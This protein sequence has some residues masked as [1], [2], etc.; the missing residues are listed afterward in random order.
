MRK[1][2]SVRKKVLCRKVDP[3]EMWCYRR[4]LKISYKGRVTNKGVPRNSG[5]TLHFVK[6][7]RKRKLE[8]AGHVMRGSTSDSHLY[9]Y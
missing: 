9:I 2:I 4:I 3:F 8:F 1:N 7:M 6:N 5:A